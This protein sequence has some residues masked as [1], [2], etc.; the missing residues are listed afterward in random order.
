MKEEHACDYPQILAACAAFCDLME[1]SHTKGHVSADLSL[2]TTHGEEHPHT[3]T[4]TQN[5]QTNSLFKF[6]FRGPRKIT[7][8]Q[9]ESYKLARGHFGQI[10][11]T[12]WF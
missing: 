3:H 1:K 9:V 2:R 6:K 8:G 7:T 11:T 5:T 12:V 4:H 10:V